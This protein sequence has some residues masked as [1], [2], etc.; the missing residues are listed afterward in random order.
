MAA[1]SSSS[2][3]I[4]KATKIKIFIF[5]L[6]GNERELVVPDFSYYTGDLLARDVAVAFGI[7][8]GEVS[9]VKFGEHVP[10]DGHKHLYELNLTDNC[11]L[12]LV[13]VKTTVESE[14]ESEESP[15]KCL[16]C[17][18]RMTRHIWEVLPVCRMC[19]A[20]QLDQFGR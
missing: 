13:R 5:E 20:D 18:E 8:L 3:S 7:P 12:Q 14:D 2:S 15:Y 1:S 6:D 19:Y 10:I 17:S 4:I 16:S 11:A 9:L